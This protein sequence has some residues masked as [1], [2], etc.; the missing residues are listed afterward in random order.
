[1]GES[2]IAGIISG[3]I[4][5]VFL[6]VIM[7]RIKPNIH[8]ADD[9]CHDVNDKKYRIKFVNKS[10]ANLVDVKYT[11]HACYRS[12]DGI[13]DIQEVQPEKS[14]LE[15]VQAYSKA[16]TDADYAVRISYDLSNYI[17][18]EYSYFLFTIYAKHS[19]SGTSRFVRKE[20]RKDA[21]KCGKFETGK[22]TK[23]IVAPCHKSYSA[24]E[25]CLY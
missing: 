16:D 15:F 14:R 5:S 8:I 11:L 1:M 13:I 10:R 7:F 21:I 3:V 4:A 25:K 2:I 12:S 6:Y 24:C 23:V 9:I 18:D 22:S 17:S 20:F 19:W